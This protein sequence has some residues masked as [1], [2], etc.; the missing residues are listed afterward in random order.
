MLAPSTPRRWLTWLR[1]PGHSSSSSNRPK[2]GWTP[3]A[4]GWVTARSQRHRETQQT[5]ENQIR[6]A[7]IP[8]TY[9][10]NVNS[11]DR[12]I[13]TVILCA[14]C[15]LSIV[16]TSYVQKVCQHVKVPVFTIHLLKLMLI[17]PPP[18]YPHRKASGTAWLYAE[19]ELCWEQL[20]ELHH[21]PHWLL[22]LLWVCTVHTPANLQVQAGRLLVMVVVVV[23]LTWCNTV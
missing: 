6:S 18:P 17:L 21:C 16:M 22:D 9:N 11:K 12:Q 19:R 20:Y 13:P 1:A 5:V 10:V 7:S 14:F 23:D 2:D 4:S 15:R 3:S 8:S